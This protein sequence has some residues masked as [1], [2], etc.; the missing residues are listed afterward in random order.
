M[1]SELVILRCARVFVE[2]LLCYFVRSAL[3]PRQV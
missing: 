1:A 3:A 2:G